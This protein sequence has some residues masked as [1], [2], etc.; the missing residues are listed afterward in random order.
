MCILSWKRKH[1]TS[2]EWEAAISW[3]EEGQQDKGEAW[4]V[5]AHSAMQIEELAIY[6]CMRSWR[7]KTKILAIK[8]DCRE[9]VRALCDITK[10]AKEI[11]QIIEHIHILAPEMDYI[12]CAYVKRIE[13][14]K[15]HSLAVKSRKRDKGI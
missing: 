7:E 14:S 9:V 5:F 1:K 8:S 2:A 11:Q 10:A 15:A 4:R 13:V 6:H 3:S 12:S